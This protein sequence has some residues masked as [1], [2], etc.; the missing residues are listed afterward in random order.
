[1]S[2][3]AEI[4][5]DKIFED[6]ENSLGAFNLN[7]C[8]GAVTA[9]ELNSDK[10]LFFLT[11]YGLPSESVYF[12]YYD[13][14]NGISYQST[15]S[16]SFVE[17]SILGSYENPYLIEFKYDD[18]ENNFNVFPNPFES[19]FN[20]SFDVSEGQNFSISIYDLTGRHIKTVL[21]EYRDIGNYDIDISASDLA[22]GLYIIQLD[23]EVSSSKKHIIK[24]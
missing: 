20:I 12:K 11:V 2:I 15:N 3:I 4:N 18:D 16:I 17:N 1:M 22:K 9:T 10:N 24:L 21:D 19:S 7:E 8:L 5:D 6:K 23:G 14:L 13:H